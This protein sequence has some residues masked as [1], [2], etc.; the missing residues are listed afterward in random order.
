[1][2]RAG[3]KIFG[4]G[5]V[6]LVL[7]RDM[8]KILLLK[9]NKAKRKKWGY[10]WGNVGGRTELG[11]LML[12]ACIREAREE[13]GL[14]LR[15]KDVKLFAIKESPCFTP[16]VHAMHF[17]YF[18][19]IDE[20]TRVCINCESDKCAWFSVNKLPKDIID[21]DLANLIKLVR[22]KSDVCVLPGVRV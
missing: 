15:K 1:M 17:F 9:R 16:E 4:L 8:T 10:S 22:K 14:K 21:A 5:V 6:L 11:E 19:K 2:G 18:T 13:I 12:D 20:N 7:N 3:N